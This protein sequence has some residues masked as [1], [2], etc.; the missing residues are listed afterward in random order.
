MNR[1]C[2]VTLR[3]ASDKENDAP[4]SLCPLK[5]YPA[6]S[7][8]ADHKPVFNSAQEPWDRWT[9]SADQA[10]SAE[11]F[12]PLFTDGVDSIDN[13]TA[14][15]DASRHCRQQHSI[16]GPV[17]H[18]YAAYSSGAIRYSLAAEF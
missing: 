10:P 3:A 14:V 12:M 1:G 18:I 5:R 13:Y 7:A 15:S 2:L 16:W 9:V 4:L 8:L 11:C 6:G 17:R